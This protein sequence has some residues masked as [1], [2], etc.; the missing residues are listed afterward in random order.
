MQSR[1]IG[2]WIICGYIFATQIS[3]LYSFLRLTL[4]PDPEIAWANSYYQDL[5]YWAIAYLLINAVLW[6]AAVVFL[7]FLR[8]QAFPLFLVAAIFGIGNTAW[9]AVSPWIASAP[10]DQSIAKPIQYVGL[11]VG[12]IVLGAIVTYVWR[13]KTKGVLL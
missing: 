12:A 3:A 11:S 6:L 13:L 5:S 2:V 4:D 9:Q 1:P 7:F 8:K 10:I